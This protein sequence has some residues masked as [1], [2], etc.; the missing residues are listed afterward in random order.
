MA[1]RTGK[2]GITGWMSQVDIAVRTRQRI[3]LYGNVLDLVFDETSGSLPLIEWLWRRLLTGGFQR[4]LHYDYVHVPRLLCGEMPAAM[5]NPGN[6][7][8]MRIDAML[9]LLESV[10]ADPGVSAEPTVP[11]ESM[12]LV[13]TALILSDAERIIRHPSR[14]SAL[15]QGLGGDGAHRDA[16]RSLI[17]HLYTRDNDIP[18]AFMKADPDT[19]VILVPP[20]SFSQ[21]LA[22]FDSLGEGARLLQFREHDVPITTERLARVTEGYRLRELQQLEELAEVEEV[23]GNLTSLLSLFRFGRKYDYWV[24]QNVE[25]IMSQLHEIVLGQDEAIDQVRDSLYRAKQ[26]VDALID[27]T[28]RY[29]AMVLFFVGGTGVGKTLMARAICEAV[30]GTIENLEVIDMAEYQQEHANQRLIGSPPGYVGYEEGGQLTNW[31]QERPYSIVLFDEIEKAHE[32]IL[33]LFLQILDGARLTSGKGLTV[34][35]SETILI[36]T[37]NIGANEALETE[38]NRNDREAVATHFLSQV[39]A[40]FNEDL[41]RPELFNRLKK[42]IIVFNF[43]SEEMARVAIEGKLRSV[44]EGVR[45]RLATRD[46]RIVFDPTTP[47]DKEV[48]DKLVAY[49]NVEKYGLR[50]VNTALMQLSGAGVG[51]FLDAP[52]P[53]EYCFRWDPQYK[54]IGMVRR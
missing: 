25:K 10:L 31:V 38:L 46:I 47:R 26:H 20:P 28:G 13:R 22:Y 43:L 29:P 35:L 50:D 42:G 5:R 33:D 40:F 32:R 45:Q 7:P 51:R 1:G 49:A 23:D 3:V 11:E 24:D 27:D 52:R 18:Q 37:S 36:F 34:D 44:A 41:G 12:P 15:L 30:M 16:L 2:A 53:G 9:E 14:E 4:I 48:I 54:K 17:I 8:P 19:I 21:R 39:E 6:M